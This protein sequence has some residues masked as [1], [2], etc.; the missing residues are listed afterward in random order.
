MTR[1]KWSRNGWSDDGASPQFEPQFASLMNSAAPPPQTHSARRSAAGPGYGALFEPN[2]ITATSERSSAARSIGLD[3]PGPSSTCCTVYPSP[4]RRRR[5]SN[6]PVLPGFCDGS[7][8][9]ERCVSL[10]PPRNPPLPGPPRRKRIVSPAAALDARATKKIT[11]D[12]GRKRSSMTPR[13]LRTGRGMSGRIPYAAPH[14]RT[15]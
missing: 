10:P 12:D 5:S 14:R 3:P 2:T 1:S 7:F 9:S 4:S 6:Q 11:Q 8:T 13:I 15:S